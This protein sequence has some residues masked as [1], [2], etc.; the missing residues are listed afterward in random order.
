MRGIEV[1]VARM[2]EIPLLHALEVRAYAAT[3]A[4]SAS[5]FHDRASRFLRGFLVVIEDGDIRALL[6]AVKSRVADLADEDIKAEGGHDDDGRELVILSVAT[7]PEHRRRGFAGLLLAAL[8]ERAPSMDVERIRLLCKP[9]LVPFYAR[10]GFRHV[11]RSESRYGGV[12]WDEME[13]P[14]RAVHSA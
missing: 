11:A 1:R 9:H 3:E 12:M 8:C 6:C 4:A 13:Q 10:H 5:R 2:D 7:E 14:V